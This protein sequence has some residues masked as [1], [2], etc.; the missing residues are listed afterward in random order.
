VDTII[1]LTKQVVDTADLKVLDLKDIKDHV[2]A[3]QKCNDVLSQL[4]GKVAIWL[5]PEPLYI[6]VALM[7]R[8]I[9][10]PLNDF[11]I[12]GSDYLKGGEAQHLGPKASTNISC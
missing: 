7:Q 4:E 10:W 11:Q 9:G 5:D 8:E 1:I 2:D 6:G 3:I 12:A